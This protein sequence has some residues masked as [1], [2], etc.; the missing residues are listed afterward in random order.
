MAGDDRE[1]LLRR[2]GRFYGEQRFAIAWTNTN[3]ADRGDPKKVSTPGWQHTRPLAG[4]DI[5]EMIFGRGMVCNPAIVLRPSGLI[6]IECDGEQDLATIE[7]LGLP[8]TLTER[9]SLPATRH[10]YFR[11]PPEL[12][13]V[14]KVSFRF[15]NGTLTAAE[16]NYYVCAPALHES[17]A[18]YAHLPGLGPGEV[19][20]AALP[21]ATYVRLVA[22]AACKQ[23]EQRKALVSDPTT[24]VT[25][26]GR[27]DL[28]FRFACAMRR[29]TSSEDE[30]LRLALGYNAE[31]CDPPMSEQRVRSQVRGA[32]KMG[33]RPP[34]P[35][36]L[37]LLRQADRFLS[38]FLA[39]NVK[40]ASRLGSAKPP[41]GRRRELRRRAASTIEARA[42]EW[43]IVNL[44]ALGTLC[45]IAGIG[46]LGKSLLALAWAARATRDGVNVLIVS[47]EDAA[48][49][50][51]RPRF[52]ALGGD[53]ERLF[54]LSLDPLDGSISFPLDLDELARHAIET[55]ARLIVI[56]PVSASIDVKL[57]A[58]KD[59]D[60]RV[61]LGR[62]A[63]LA[64]KLNLAVVM[65]AHLNKA[66]SLDPYMRIN[67]STAFY[68]ASRSVL[69]VTRDPTDDANRLIT[70]HKSNYGV[71]AP[72]E[73]WRL[74]TV[75]VPSGAGP[76]SVARLVFLE[77]ADDVSRDEVLAPPSPAEKHARAEALILAELAQGRRHSAQVKAAGVKAGISERTVKRAAAKL[78][79]VIEE[80]T[81]R[82]GRVTYWALPNWLGGR[83]TL[84]TSD[85]GPTPSQPHNEA[86]EGDQANG[87]GQ[88][89]AGSPGP[90]PLACRKHADASLWRARDGIWRCRGCDPP[91]SPDE[92][93]EEWE[94]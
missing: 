42:V 79:V 93:V 46:G 78:G 44:V 73:R 74:E 24:K 19:E 75:E 87:S 3:R 65:I 48:E 54:E 1:A 31:H 69:T 76:L 88:A 89:T 51:I 56:D 16:S 13:V 23:R 80:K 5:G 60:M 94:G 68:N 41:S 38:E 64:E 17:G 6:G 84:Y 9:S 83:A 4:G 67:G 61:V 62:L 45:L 34:D 26:G 35:D 53:L 55:S 57:D 81:T 11:P 10:F 86:A 59:R 71:L 29:W 12:E 92:V 50:V 20:I 21:A 18:I 37:D 85:A 47:F 91:A 66:P 25:V 15:E 14:A 7:A 8:T 36:D 30:I 72:V 58:H 43:L 2:L 77:L 27:H 39:G 40:V 28:I 70:L 22:E 82:S 52:E 63:K 49:Q 33:G 32:I 90:T